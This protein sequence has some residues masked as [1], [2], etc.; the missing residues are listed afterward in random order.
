MAGSVVAG[1]IAKDFLL[2]VLKTRNNWKMKFDRPE[3]I[4]VLDICS[5]SGM[6]AT[7]NCVKSGAKIIHD[8]AFKKGT[9]PTSYCTLHNP[10]LE[11]VPVE[12]QTIPQTQS[13]TPKPKSNDEIGIIY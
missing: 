1:P 10:N 11:Q 8:A 7:E 12:T 6:L 9:E 4:I 13:T 2:E 5:K 3:D